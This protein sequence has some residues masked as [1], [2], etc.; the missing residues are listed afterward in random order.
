MI[1]L[2]LARGDKLEWL[3]VIWT[4]GYTLVGI[5]KHYLF[6]FLGCPLHCGSSSVKD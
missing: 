1:D 6:T 5:G 2:S 4:K 3:Q